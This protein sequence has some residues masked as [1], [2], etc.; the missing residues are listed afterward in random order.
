M[1]GDAGAAGFLAGD[2]S[3][4]FGA[5]VLATTKSSTHSGRNLIG[6]L[7]AWKNRIEGPGLPERV[8]FTILRNP[9]GE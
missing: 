4:L 5:V 8:R 3:T 9:L 1:T 6:P 7:P 2:R